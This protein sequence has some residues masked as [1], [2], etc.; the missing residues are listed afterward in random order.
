MRTVFAD[1][2]KN[3]LYIR[4]GR[5]GAA[6]IPDLLSLRRE[7]RR[8]YPGFTVLTDLTGYTPVGQKEAEQIVRLQRFLIDAGMGMAVRVAPSAVA[9]LQFERRARRSGFRAVSASRLEDGERFL[10]QWEKRRRLAM[11]SVFSEP[12]DP[13]CG[14]PLVSSGRI[15]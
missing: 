11:N 8:L 7:V 14:P 12:C 1:V 4:I 9:R 6:P 2:D 15:A 5:S 10:D 13:D 3:R